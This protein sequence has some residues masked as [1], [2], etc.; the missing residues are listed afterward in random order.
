ML[1]KKAKLSIV[2]SKILLRVYE[3]ALQI[4]EIVE[5]AMLN[6]R[7]DPEAINTSVMPTST[8]YDLASSFL[9]L[10]NVVLDSELAERNSQKLVAPHTIQ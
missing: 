10:Y 2:D 4:T 8:V 6:D 9:V 5:H 1:P 3:D 7:V